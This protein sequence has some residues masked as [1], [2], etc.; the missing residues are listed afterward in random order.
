MTTMERMTG[1]QLA[2]L[3]TEEKEDEDDLREDEDLGHDS[4]CGP[5]I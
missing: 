1:T 4:Q 5:W 2:E 3:A